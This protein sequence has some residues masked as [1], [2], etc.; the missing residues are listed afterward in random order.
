LKY[1]ENGEM[2]SSAQAAVVKNEQVRYTLDTTGISL[3]QSMGSPTFIWKFDKGAAKQG[4][5]ERTDGEPSEN[6]THFVGLATVA[7]AVM[8]HNNK[9]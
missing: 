2:R 5:V 6:C 4:D 8:A 9:W 1:N 7:H 3:N